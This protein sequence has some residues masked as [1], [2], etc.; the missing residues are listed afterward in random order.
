MSRAKPAGAA[1]PAPMADLTDRRILV[2]GA[3]SGLGRTFALALARAGAS[4]A[5]AAR[6]TDRLA[7]LVEEIAAEGGR[8][9]PVTMDVADGRSVAAGFDAAQAKIGP[10]NTVVANA[11]INS[12]GSALDLPEDELDQLL[13][14]NVKGAFLSAREGARRMIAAG[15][16]ERGD[17]RILM[18]ASI[19]AVKVLPGLAAYCASKAGVAMLGRSLAREWINRG[20]NVNVLCPGYIET[21]LNSDWFASEKGQRQIATFPRRRLMAADDLNDL[22]RYLCSTRSGA[23]T[24]S[25]FTVDDG[26]TL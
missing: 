24:G 13:S 1:A 20:I 22:V 25:I 8:A 26:H 19:G 21:E 16:A 14:V 11:G 12:Q 2:T 18:I 10:L 15:S 4:V 6:R 9:W 17:G 7:A 3:S 23:V 5:V